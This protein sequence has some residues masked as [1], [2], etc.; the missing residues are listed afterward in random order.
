MNAL[1]QALQKMAPDLEKELASRLQGFLGAILRSYLPQTWVL[2]SETESASMTV[3]RQGKATIVPHE[4]AGADVTIEAKQAVLLA[5]L[6]QGASSKARST[7]FHVTMH[8]G[9]G[10]TAFEFLRKRFGF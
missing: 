6:T 8:T 3:D 1:A 7:D 10:K 4:V 9:K 5:A 2:K